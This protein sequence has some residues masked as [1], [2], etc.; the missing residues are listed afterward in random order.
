MKSIQ[1]LSTLA[2]LFICITFFMSASVVPTHKVEKEY[3]E[4]K[5]ASKKEKRA[6]A[7]EAK[8]QL[9]KQ[10]RVAKLQTKLAKATN[11]KTKTRLQKKI[12]A[13]KDMD[14]EILSIIAL[15]FAFVFP[16]V[17]LVL[18]IIARNNGGGLIAD[19]AFWVSIILIILYLIGILAWGLRIR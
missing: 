13:N 17:G 18:A 4:V 19:I 6:S 11:E 5:K 3:T 16:P 12:D 7:K 8:Q 1:K 14:V 9:R 15:I 2:L 10:V